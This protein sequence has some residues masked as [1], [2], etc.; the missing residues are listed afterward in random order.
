MAKKKTPDERLA[1]AE[2]KAKAELGHLL[3][4]LQRKLEALAA[5]GASPSSATARDILGVTAAGY[6]AAVAA[7]VA[8]PRR[9]R[10]R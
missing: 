7:A 2:A 4:D 6:N 1:E 9:R 5:A 3:V 10:R 8:R